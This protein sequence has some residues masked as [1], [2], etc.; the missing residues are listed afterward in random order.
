MTIS[1]ICSSQRCSARASLSPDGSLLAVSNLVR[2]FDIY[3][4]DTQEP[5]GMV[6]QKV[7]TQQPTPVLFIH[8]GK[9]IVC[10]STSSNL[11]LWDVDLGK[12]HSLVIPSTY[13]LQRH[14]WETS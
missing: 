11:Q 10:G 7:G 8:G 12:L 14:A 6:P 1:D 5:V 4:T 2:G 9:A 3:R 13:L